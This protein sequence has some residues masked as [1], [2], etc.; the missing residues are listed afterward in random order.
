M[1]ANGISLVKIAMLS[2]GSIPTMTDPSGSN[3]RCAG[4][5]ELYWEGTRFGAGMALLPP[6]GFLFMAWFPEG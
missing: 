1:T 4:P 2:S 6:S 5:I 3:L